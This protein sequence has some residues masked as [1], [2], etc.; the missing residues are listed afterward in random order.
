MDEIERQ[1]EDRAWTTAKTLAEAGSREFFAGQRRIVVRY[2]AHLGSSEARALAA[3]LIGSCEGKLH[4][5]VT[6]DDRAELA[7]G[8]TTGTQDTNR[9]SMHEECILLQSPDVNRC[10]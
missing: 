3:A 4:V 7:T 5:R 9:D 10:L 8:V 6:G 2:E 1:S